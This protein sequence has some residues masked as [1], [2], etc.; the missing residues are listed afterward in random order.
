MSVNKWQGNKQ[1]LILYCGGYTKSAQII[2]E[3]LGV[4]FHRQN[5]FGWLK[6]DRDIPKKYLD[7]LLEHIRHTGARMIEFYGT[8]NENDFIKKGVKDV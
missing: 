1:A 3:K 7:V 8:K 2:S 5:V 6:E 4:E